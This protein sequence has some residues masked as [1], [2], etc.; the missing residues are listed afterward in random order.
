MFK[1]KLILTLI[2]GLMIYTCM[3]PNEDLGVKT[4]LLLTQDVGGYCVDLGLADSIIIAAAEENGFFSFKIITDEKNNIIRFDTLAHENN[5][6]PTV[7]DNMSEQI[8]ISSNNN[9][10]F[11]LDKLDRI[12]VRKLNGDIIDDLENLHNCS[13]S[14]IR[15]IAIDDTP[16][17]HIILYSLVKHTSGGPS[18]NPYSTSIITL[19]LEYTYWPDYEITTWN[20]DECHEYHNLNYGCEDIFFTDSLLAVSNGTLGVNVFKQSA[21]S[22]YSGELEEL[23]SFDTE[24]EVNTVFVKE[25]NIFAGLNDDKGC[26][27]ST[28]NS[29]N[30]VS[31]QMYIANGYSIQGIHIQGDLMALACGGDGI[32]LYNFYNNGNIPQASEIGRINSEYA[33]K[34]KIYNSNTI[35]AATREGVQIF[36]IER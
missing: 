25:N 32:L 29:D 19:K 23:L 3:S 34:V 11:S 13:Y 31:N 9:M 6:F 4:N 17:D 33:Y 14:L 35:F 18:Y 5:M 8:E 7:G 21:D 16:S 36:T 27:I 20:D 28:I 15:S 12:H 1:I 24:G 30:T 10:F 22:D 2:F 26:C